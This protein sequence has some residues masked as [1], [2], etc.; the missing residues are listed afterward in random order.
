MTSTQQ[1][2]NYLNEQLQPHLWKDYCPNG[3]QVSGSKNIQHL[4]TAVTASQEVL[5][6][7]VQAKA[8]A[9]LVHH[10]YF[11]RGED[12]CIYGIK[13]NRLL[14]LLKHDLNLIAYHLPLDGHAEWGNNVQLA[15]LLDLRITGEFG[16][17]CG[18]AL[19]LVGDLPSAMSGEEFAKYL[20]QKLNRAPLHLPGNASKIKRIAWCTGAAQD[21]IEEAA[22]QGVDA[23]LTG[24]ISERTVYIAKESGL[25]FFAA[26]HHATERYG[27]QAL[28]QHLAEQF[29]LTHQY[30]ESDN[31]I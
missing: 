18:P 22:H 20:Q 10:G 16:Y 14:T 11:W 8:Q 4:V 9:I 25:H 2:I 21:L 6:A 29:S 23:Y 17:Q 26:G 30:I 31:P 12:P 7:A 5:E 1:I 3:L 28:G 19:A 27:V 24:E 13:K 15:R